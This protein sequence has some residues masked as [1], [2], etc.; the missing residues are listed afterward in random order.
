MG[1][2]PADEEKLKEEIGMVWS[3]FKSFV[4]EHRPAFDVEKYG[5][6]ETWFGG[7]AL[8]RNLCDELANSDDVILGKLDRGAEIYSVRF[9]DPSETPLLEKISDLLHVKDM[10]R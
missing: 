6:G 10:L 7:D 3:Q 8:A 1:P 9:K 2:T 4:R 5:T